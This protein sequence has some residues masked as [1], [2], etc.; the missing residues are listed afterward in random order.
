MGAGASMTDYASA[1]QN[2]DAASFPAPFAGVRAGVEEKQKAGG[3]EASVLAYATEECARL[4]LDVHLDT[5]YSS[6]TGRGRLRVTC[7][8]GAAPGPAAAPEPNK[9]PRSPRDL[10]ASKVEWLSA[11][12][13][14]ANKKLLDT[15]TQTIVVLT[16]G[17][18]AAHRAYQVGKAWAKD[19]DT[20]T[21]MHVKSDKDYT[22]D[23]FKSDRIRARYDA[24]LTGYL[25]E[26]RRRLLT[27]HKSDTETTRASVA[28]WVNGCETHA[29]PSL[30]HRAPNFLVLGFSGRKE[31]TR[32]PYVLGQVAD[33][34]LR[35]VA[36][37]CVIVKREPTPGP[38]KLKLFVCDADRC[39]LAYRPARNPTRSA[40]FGVPRESFEILVPPSNRIR[41]PRFLD[42]SSSLLSSRRRE[43]APL[44][45][46]SG[47][48]KVK[49]S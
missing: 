14:K 3:D 2:S 36:C 11:A 40:G 41:S 26:E 39:W 18:A 31:P 4:K 7:A 20:L 30:K 47:T 44:K 21:V 43:R 32:D 42:R 22:T 9:S 24:E 48:L 38:R 37:P 49:V 5:E 13:I 46:R 12:V 10:V 8:E 28:G 23:E 6:A 27:V 19:D 1:V 33:L 34:S 29:Q 16:D 35:S 45:I 15:P 17:S 25:P